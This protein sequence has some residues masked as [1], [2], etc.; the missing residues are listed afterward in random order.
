VRALA[1]AGGG[2]AASR[3][4]AWLAERTNGGRDFPASPIGL[5]FARLWYW[6]RLYPLVF[7]VAGL[8]RQ[9]AVAPAAA[10]TS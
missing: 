1:A 2:R 4:A 5:Y 10:L 8:R 6:E 3:G 9:S 7:A